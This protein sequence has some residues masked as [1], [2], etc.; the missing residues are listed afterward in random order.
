MRRSPDSEPQRNSQLQNVPI[1]PGSGRSEQWDRL[2]QF[3]WRHLLFLAAAVGISFALIYVQM[4]TRLFFAFDT[5]RQR[6][7]PC[8]T[9]IRPTRGTNTGSAWSNFG[10]CPDASR[11]ADRETIVVDLRYGM[12]L[13]YKTEPVMQDVLPM[14]F[15]H[16]LRNLDPDSRAFGKGGTHTLDMGLVGDNVSLT[17]VDLVMAGGG[18]V[19]YVPASK[20]G[21][22]A[23]AA[24]GYLDDSTLQW[25]G[26]DWRIRHENGIEMV[27]PESQNATRF[28]Q[29]ALVQMSTLDGRTL[30]IDRDL[31]G[32]VRFVSDGRNR[33]DF[34]HDAQNRIKAIS[35]DDTGQRLEFDYDTR[36]C[37]VRRTGAGGEF[38]YEYEPRG[39]GCKLARTEHNGV[40]H[41][42][43]EYGAD[44]R[45]IKLTGPE[46]GTYLVSYETD[47]RG[48][49]VRADVRDPDGAL[50]RITIDE[51]GYWLS[52]WGSY[53]GQ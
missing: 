45:L 4:T 24:A 9:L 33:V 7:D 48:V 47:K 29:T 13:H 41:F 27:F 22:F 2:L 51:T 44:D 36:G 28:E 50:R 43:A 10:S 42:R 18:R 14:P 26:K 21:W 39:A 5:A 32:N 40:T 1:T 23:P 17:W 49:I 12:L 11:D 34:E 30:V 15:A 53:R 31:A 38:L 25:N 8:L 6:G 52:H 46:G 19:H 16:V 20:P 35:P 37:L 3:A